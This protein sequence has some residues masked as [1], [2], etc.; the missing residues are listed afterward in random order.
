MINLNSNFAE[1]IPDPNR[2][3]WNNFTN[4]LR[5]THLFAKVH[6][7][8]ETETNGN[9]ISTNYQLLLFALGSSR[10]EQDLQFAAMRLVA[11]MGENLA[12]A[13]IDELN[14]LLSDYEFG[15]TL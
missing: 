9:A 2:T 12:A 3:R 15:F 8:S 10:N 11:A 7:A 1:S 13:D 6:A 14:L 4:Q 5:G